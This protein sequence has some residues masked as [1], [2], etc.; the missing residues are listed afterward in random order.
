MDPI[1]KPLIVAVVFA[2]GIFAI[3]YSN[4][5][6]TKC[7]AQIEI[8]KANLA[9]E[10]F[11]KQGKKLTFSPRIMKYLDTCKIGNGPGGCF[12]LQKSMERLAREVQNFSDECTI[13][14]GEVAE[15]RRTLT[16]TLKLMVQVAWGE[17]PP[18]GTEKRA[19]WFDSGDLVIFCRVRTAFERLYGQEAYDQF[20]LGVA[21][22]LP[23]EA[24]K[25][26]DAK[27]T[28]CEFRKKAK[29]VLSPDEIYKRTLFSLPCGSFR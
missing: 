9:G 25:F 6:Y 10:F 27:C 28:N 21:A 17:A 5:Q 19:G 15:V 11:A 7:D 8:F 20:R 22:N 4:P 12:E 2:L 3:M 29:D 24:P 13:Q 26:E 23:G 16:E 1:P 18:E 14:L